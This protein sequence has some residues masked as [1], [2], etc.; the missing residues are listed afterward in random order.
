MKV[1]KLAYSA[2][3]YGLF[4]AVFSYF[5][6]FVAGDALAD[7]LPL[8]QPLKTVDSGWVALSIPGLPAV[9]SNIV[10]LLMF[11]LQHSLMARQSFKR[12]IDRFI[13]KEMERSTYVLATCAVL[14]WMYIAWQPI[15]GL[16]WQI[17]GFA[18]HLMAA[19]FLMGAALVLWSTFMIS[20]WQLF[21]L[22]QAWQAFCGRE[23]AEPAFSKPAMYKYT[24]HPL[25]L[26]LLLVLWATPQMT[27]GHIVMSVVWT[28]YIFIGIGYEEKDL[29]KQF[30]DEYRQYMESVPQLFPF[31][32]KG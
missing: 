21:G 7:C 19:L 11:A 2:F 18:V 6:V 13:P 10:L 9:A 14:M 25:Y 5:V 30:G 32:R 17:E 23:P 16:V 28:I 29:L 27:I 12:L 3:N 22:S 24:R 15:P 31:L 20:H 26:G 8:M 4:L 1:I